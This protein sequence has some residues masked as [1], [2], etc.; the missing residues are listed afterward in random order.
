MNRFLREANVF[1][2]LRETG[3]LTGL[4]NLM[5]YGLVDQEPLGVPTV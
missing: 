3:N 2:I 5:H 1:C 4:S